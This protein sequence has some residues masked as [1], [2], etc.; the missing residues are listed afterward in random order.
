LIENGDHERLDYACR[1]V[2][3]MRPKV[4]EYATK[5]TTLGLEMDILKMAIQTLRQEA[6]KTT[7]MLD[8][9]KDVAL[10]AAFTALIFMVLHFGLPKL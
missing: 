10:G 9:W 8:R 3:R 2:E 5:I 4:H 6:G 1:E 7:G